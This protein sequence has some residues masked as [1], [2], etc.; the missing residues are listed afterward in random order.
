MEGV[1][2]RWVRVAPQKVHV[3]VRNA[4]IIQ[5]YYL[6]AALLCHCCTTQ[7]RVWLQNQEMLGNIKENSSAF[8]P[9]LLGQG[10]RFFFKIKKEST[11]TPSAGGVWI[12]PQGFFRM[13]KSIPI[14][15]LGAIFFSNYFIY[16]YVKLVYDQKI[17]VEISISQYN[18]SQ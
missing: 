4:N 10:V 7:G 3:C 5:W 14:L 1:T 2:Q 9:S 12:G 13:S 16:L 8:R 15:P 6:T 11:Q 17:L 18:R